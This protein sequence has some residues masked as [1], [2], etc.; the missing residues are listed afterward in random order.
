[1]TLEER[2]AEF[3]NLR[4][5]LEQ[6]I[7][8]LATSIDGRNFELQASLHGLELQVGSYLVLE[9]GAE[10]RLGQV[11]TLELGQVEGSHV[12]TDGERGELRTPM[13]VRLA[14]GAG[15]V[16]DGDGRPFHDATVR[17]ADEADVAAWQVS[18]RPARAGLE[19]GELLLAPGVRAL[20]DAGGFNRHTLL[21]GQSGSGKTYSLGLVL[22]RLLVETDLDVIVLDPNSDFIRLGELRADIDEGTG[23]RFAAAAF[24]IAVRRAGDA[25][26]LRADQL[27]PRARA[28]ALGLDPIADRE[29]FA[30]VDELLGEGGLTLEELVTSDNPLARALRLRIRNLGIDSWQLWAQGRLESI[31]DD[32]DGRVARCLVIDLGSL[33]TREEQ[34]VAAEAVLASLWRRREQRKPVLIVIDEAHNVCPNEPD[35]PVTALATEHAVRI[36][37]EGRKFG[38]Y[39]LI[40][41]QRPQKIHENV[42]TQCDNLLLMRMN[43]QADLGYMSDI[44]SFV[45]RS[46]LA[47]ATTFRQGEALMAGKIA[48]HPGF[49]RFGARIA[50]EGGSDIPADW[51]RPS[52]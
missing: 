47:R 40:S 26:C 16:L 29:E 50:Q 38:L 27:E 43:S 42:L 35:N 8:P 14:R 28:A 44:F 3:R 7:L 20:L 10:R 36:A 34:A 24:G 12:A 11:L 52:G 51:A 2:T 39:L 37:A 48:S 9:D 13:A 15:V 23:S 41:T 49:V 45:P 5:E 4:R 22:E 32:V 19:I 46:L 33:A 30:L 6:G 31:V 21:C 25:L 1:M 17:P 18:I